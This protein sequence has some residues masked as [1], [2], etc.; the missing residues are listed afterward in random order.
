MGE[1]WGDFIATILQHS[2]T[3]KRSD[4][5]AMGVYSNNGIS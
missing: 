1:G 2:P 5:F 4:D 3:T